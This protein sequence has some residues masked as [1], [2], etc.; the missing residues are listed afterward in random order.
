[1]FGDVSMSKKR[2]F[3]FGAKLCGFTHLGGVLKGFGG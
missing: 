1:M 3:L 2:R